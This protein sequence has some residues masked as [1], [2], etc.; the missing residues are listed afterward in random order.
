MSGAEI[1]LTEILVDV[2]H[3]GIRI[4]TQLCGNSILD[5]IVLT[6]YQEQK[7]EDKEYTFCFHVLELLLSFEARAA[8]EGYDGVFADHIIKTVSMIDEF[9]DKFTDR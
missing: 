2:L 3:T 6:R 5:S 9:A 7:S 8:A 1:V 4:L